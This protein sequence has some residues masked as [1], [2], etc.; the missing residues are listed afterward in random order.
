MA[1]SLWT[2]SN[3]DLSSTVTQILYIKNEIPCTSACT[4]ETCQLSFPICAILDSSFVSRSVLLLHEFSISSLYPHSFHIHSHSY[5]LRLWH[6]TAKNLPCLRAQTQSYIQ[7]HSLYIQAHANM[8]IT[9]THS[10]SCKAE[11][12]HITGYTFY[13]QKDSFIRKHHHTRTQEALR[14]MH[15]L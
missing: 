13:I 9:K 4:N 5:S 14:Q 10:F 11:G 7:T 8:Q 1:I 12:E 3:F 15:V 6:V 2:I